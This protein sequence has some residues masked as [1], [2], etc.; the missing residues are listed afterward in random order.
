MAMVT[1]E[2]CA[3]GAISEFAMEPAMAEAK[4]QA[5]VSFLHHY[6]SLVVL[7]YLVWR[8]QFV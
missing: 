6:A 4:A 7:S 2:V 1:V 3:Q 5:P 8:L